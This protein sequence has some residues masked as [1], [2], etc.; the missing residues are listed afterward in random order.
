MG[1]CKIVRPPPSSERDA[2]T[3]AR[4]RATCTSWRLLLSRTD[5]S[6]PFALHAHARLCI[7]ADLA[8]LRFSRHMR[9]LASACS[10]DSLL[11]SAFQRQLND[12]LVSC[13]ERP[14]VGGVT[15][16]LVELVGID[17]L[18]QE[19]RRVLGVLDVAQRELV[20]AHAVLHDPVR[21]EEMAGTH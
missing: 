20:A 12:H 17:P 9:M 18:R 15:H 21:L 14:R 2:L 3:L 1:T 7:P 6:A 13:H 4:L 8:L 5:T 16:G 10:R 19:V 11:A